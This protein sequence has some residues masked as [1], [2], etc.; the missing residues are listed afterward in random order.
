M[1]TTQLRESLKQRACE[2]I[3]SLK[4]DLVGIS[5]DIH[6]HPEENFEEHYAHKRLTDAIGDNKLDVTRKAYDI[7]TA[8]D[9]AVGSK[10]ATVAVLCEY[11]ALPGIGHA[12]GHNIIAAAGLGANKPKSQNAPQLRSTTT[13]P[14]VKPKTK[15]AK[16]ASTLIR[17][18]AQAEKSLAQANEKQSKLL[19]ELALAKG[20][21]AAL[22]KVSEELA[23]AQAVVATAE[24]NWIALAAEA[25]AQGLNLG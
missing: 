12:C 6:A 14:S 11:D 17:L 24:E 13:A 1:S 5:H 9:V 7:D 25:E 10:G 21:H 16:S 4:N 23:A 18:V 2:K 20:D 15:P 8:F 3:D 22:A 19:A